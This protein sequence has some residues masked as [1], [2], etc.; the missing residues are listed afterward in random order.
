VN[1]VTSIP[2]SAAGHAGVSIRPPPTR[3]CLVALLPCGAVS[4]GRPPP[5][6][7]AAGHRYSLGY[8][9]PGN[10]YPHSVCRHAE[11]PY[12]V[13]YVCVPCRKSNK[14]PWDGAEHLCPECRAPMVFAGHDFA[15]PRRHDKSGWAAVAAV[16]EAGLRYEGFE[17]CGCSRDP[18]FR[19]RTSAQVRERRQLADRTG[20]NV[21]VM[22]A[23]RDPYSV[24]DT[25][26]QSPASEPRQLRSRSSDRRGAL[27]LLCPVVLEQGGDPLVVGVV[28]QLVQEVIRAEIVQVSPPSAALVVPDAVAAWDSSR[29]VLP[30]AHE[31][32]SRR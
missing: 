8:S 1:S 15:A 26:D 24:V 18:K 16:L 14:Y 10:G 9:D 4:G 11:T 2:D 17:T 29:H 30:S 19:P 23:A 12:K 5:S 7:A 25:A 32:L 6:A 13:H 27:P 3:A 21:A 20:V 28:V 22:L 31:A